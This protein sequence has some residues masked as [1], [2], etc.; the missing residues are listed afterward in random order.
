M[1]LGLP[2]D[3]AAE[4]GQSESSTRFDRDRI[5]VVFVT[6][7]A[8][9]VG[10]NIA[11]QTFSEIRSEEDAFVTGVDEVPDDTLDCLTMGL[12]GRV[13]EAGDLV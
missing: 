5:L 6:I 1:Q 13:G 3:G 2:N 12:A 7:E 9:K 4:Q 11:I 8:R 10:I